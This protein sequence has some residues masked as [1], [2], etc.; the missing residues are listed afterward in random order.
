LATH[1]KVS[2]FAI[3]PPWPYLCNRILSV[4]LEIPSRNAVPSAVPSVNRC[5]G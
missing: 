5:F 2:F 3:H 1:I 4:A